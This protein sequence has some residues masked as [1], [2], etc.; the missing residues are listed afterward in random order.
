VAINFLEATSSASA[1]K[2]F[3]I[4][5]VQ[6]SATHKIC[7]EFRQKARLVLPLIRAQLLLLCGVRYKSGL[8]PYLDYYFLHPRTSF[9]CST[10]LMNIAQLSRASTTEELLD[11]SPSP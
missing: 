11:D 8:F 4:T 3:L 1:D 10:K 5:D 6:P 2:Q 9:S 7:I